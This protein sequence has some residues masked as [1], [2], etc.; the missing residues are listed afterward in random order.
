MCWS[1][2]KQSLWLINIYT[3]IPVF[4]SCYTSC[5]AHVCWRIRC[6]GLIW[7]VRELSEEKERQ[8]INVEKEHY[9]MRLIIVVI[10]KCSNC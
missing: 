1:Y 6:C 5:E 2:T 7:A 9:E 10:K 4:T 8:E 3:D